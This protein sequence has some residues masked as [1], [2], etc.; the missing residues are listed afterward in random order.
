MKFDFPFIISR[1]YFILFFSNLFYVKPIFNPLLTFILAC[2]IKPAAKFV[3]L[4]S[5]YNKTNKI[6]V[7]GHGKQSVF[8]LRCLLCNVSSVVLLGRNR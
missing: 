3:M 4:I 7:I 2:R 8:T 6:A 1:L 5:I